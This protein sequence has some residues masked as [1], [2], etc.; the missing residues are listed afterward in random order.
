MQST[1]KAEMLNHIKE[2]CVKDPLYLFK[3]LMSSLGKNIVEIVLRIVAYMVVYYIMTTY[4]SIPQGVAALIVLAVIVF[5]HS[6]VAGLEK[7]KGGMKAK[8]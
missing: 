7:I 2:E 1:S 3:I 4:L 5:Y 6:I 8:A